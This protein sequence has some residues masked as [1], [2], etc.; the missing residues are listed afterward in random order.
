MKIKLIKQFIH[1]TENLEQFILIKIIMNVDHYY[2]YIKNKMI[3]KLFKIGM[4]I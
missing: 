3:H 4:I 1:N 2:L